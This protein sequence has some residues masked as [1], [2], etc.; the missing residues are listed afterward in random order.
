MI[1]QPVE[2]ISASSGDY[3][4]GAVCSNVRRSRATER[5]HDAITVDRCSPDYGAPQW[6]ANEST[7]N[8][9]ISSYM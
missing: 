8:C 3:E 5:V 4:F 1:H 6:D 9:R 2:V 7:R